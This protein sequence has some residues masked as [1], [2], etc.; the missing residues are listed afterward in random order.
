M[1]LYMKQKVFSFR[2]R[3]TVKD[4]C[5]SD[6]YY[7]EGEIFSWSKKLHVYDSS[8][9][10]VAF[11]KQR[12]F[13]FLP[14]YELYVNG[15]FIAQ[16]VKEFSFFKPKLTISELGWEIS[17]DFWNHNY[18]ITCKNEQIAAI[19][20]EWFTWGDSYMLD[21]A[22]PKNELIALA[23]ILTIDCIQ[24]SQAASAASST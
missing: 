4:E 9:R 2:S 3:F 18:V 7:V 13:T 14:K 8:E 24:E 16:I 1:K 23:V 19:S 5:E 22:D 21:I 11:I 12:L 6:R 15:T 17:G 20:K 10:E